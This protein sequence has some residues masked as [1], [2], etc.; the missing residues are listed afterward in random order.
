MNNLTGKVVSIL[1]VLVLLV[2]SGYQ[3]YRYFYQPYR[4]ETAYLYTVTD[5]V[6]T[7]GL[8]VRAEQVV[9]GGVGG[10]M[11]YSADEGEKVI[12]G[13]TIVEYYN[14]QTQAQNVARI[15]QIEEQIAL[16]G[17]VQQPGSYQYTNAE[18]L[19]VR[20]EEII[21]DAAQAAAAGDA[22]QALRGRNDLL[23][24]M[25][26]RQLSV[27]EVQDFSATINELE[28]E[29]S[30]LQGQVSGYIDTLAAPIEGYFSRYT[31]GQEGSYT[32]ENLMTMD[33]TMLSAAIETPT[34]LRSDLPGKIMTSHNW[35]LGLVVTA[36]E[37]EKFIPGDK[38]QVRLQGGSIE[39]ITMEIY[40][41]SVEEQNAVVVLKSDRIIPE[42]L[43]LRSTDVEVHFT[44]HS[45]LRVSNSAVR[46]EDGT[47]GVYVSTGYELRFKPIEVIYQ[48]DG[49]QICSENSSLQNSIKMFDSVVV[50]GVDLYDGKPI[51]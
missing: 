5:K 24:Y 40:S 8:V 25:S 41:L 29:M 7:R 13:T 19:S 14:D 36:R 3:G 1:A 32:P 12:K 46:T 31:D 39:D 38:V 23:E 26:K 9:T 35:Y 45:G 51:F 33:S 37:A 22:T 4:T 10:V 48:G 2:Y 42:I 49:Y 50:E 30:A 28:Q 44:Q 20:I 27:G 15:A 43:S 47:V 6:Q 18:A 34:Q 21:G 16:L 11:S 17:E